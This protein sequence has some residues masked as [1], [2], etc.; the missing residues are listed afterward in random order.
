MNRTNK[1][2]ILFLVNVVFYMLL[3]RSIIVSQSQSRQS[4]KANTGNK[5]TLGLEQLQVI[6]VR[7][8]RGGFK[9]G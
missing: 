5:E 2:R 6:I 3:T 4:P 7:S 1:C 8:W 9:G